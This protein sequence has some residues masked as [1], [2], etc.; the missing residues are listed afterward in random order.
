MKRALL[1]SIILIS[2]W[3]SQAQTGT[4]RGTII[5]DATG[6]PMIGAN[7]IVPGQGM[8]AISDLDGSFSLVAAPG[9]YEIQIS[10]ITYQTIVFKSLVVEANKVNVLGEIRMKESSMQLAEVVVV[11]EM[12]R[13]SE[14]AIVTVKKRSPVI[15][16]GISAAKIKLVGDGTA[17]EAA[18]R[19]T[20]VSVEGG[21]YVYIR[22]LGDRYTRTTLNGMDIPG[23]DP[24]KNSIQL[25]IFP[26]NLISNIMVSKNFSAELPADFTGGILNIETTSFPEEKV[27]EGSFG[28]SYNP[29]MHFNSNFLDYKGGA[30]DF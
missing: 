24:D 3:Y 5:D 4:I 18:K 13:N 8:G 27:F 10:F 21:K 22:G 12:T 30:T 7:V 16:D 20:G 2:S 17:V 19:V 23:L 29:D 6:E 26:T 25:D 15:L 28:I 9:T 1:L 14:A 11:E